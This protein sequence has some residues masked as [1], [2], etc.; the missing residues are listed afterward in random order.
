MWFGRFEISLYP[1]SL[2]VRICVR[3]KTPIPFAR[4]K[5]NSLK[6]EEDFLE[7]RFGM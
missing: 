5:S 4:L 3:T 1:H 6:V 2:S 7:G